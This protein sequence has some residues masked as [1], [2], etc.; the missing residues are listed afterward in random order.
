MR[1]EIPYFSGE[2]FMNFLNQGEPCDFGENL[3]DKLE[4]EEISRKARMRR[5]QD[6]SRISHQTVGGEYF[7]C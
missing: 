3:F 2:Y 1:D 7:L 6:W 5:M 4:D